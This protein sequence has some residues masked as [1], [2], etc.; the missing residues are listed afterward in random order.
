MFHNDH[1][2]MNF[3]MKLITIDSDSIEIPPIE[4]SHKVTLN[5]DKFRKIIKH[6][7]VTG[8]DT[9]CIDSVKN[10]ICFNIFG[11]VCNTDITIK[12]NNASIEGRIKL[13]FSL[14]YLEQFLKAS[15]LSP[16]LILH[17]SDE[18]PLMIEYSIGN[19]CVLRWYNRCI[20]QLDWARWI[21]FPYF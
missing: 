10:K 3:N 7:I 9:V 12:H 13:N 21:K 19:K 2:T 18:M 14:E 1:H 17:L 5:S 20:M 8:G 16:V 6:L 4:Y 15:T 11:N